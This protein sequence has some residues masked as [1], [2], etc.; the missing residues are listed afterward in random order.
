MPLANFAPRPVTRFQNPQRTTVTNSRNNPLVNIH[1]R[2]DAFEILLAVPGIPKDQITLNIIENQLIVQA[3]TPNDEEG[4]KTTYLR[5]EYDFA[6]F[7]KIFNLNEEIDR[8]KIDA[9][10]VDGVLTIVLNKKE[11]AKTVPPRTIAIK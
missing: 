9:S 6:G 3:I 8:R 4:L 11:E 1:E 5:K 10:L 7:R 2:G